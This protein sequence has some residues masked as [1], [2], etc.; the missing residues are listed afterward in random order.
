MATKKTQ[1]VLTRGVVV[2][3]APR[4]KGAKL[5]IDARMARLLIGANKAKPVKAAKPKV[6]EPLAEE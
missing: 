5:T 2:D 6:S 3:G 1:I 4:K